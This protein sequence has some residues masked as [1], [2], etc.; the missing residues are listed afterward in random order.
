MSRFLVMVLSL[1][2]ALPAGAAPLRVVAINTDFFFY[3]KDGKPAGI[4]Y[5]IL[6]YF[7]K[8]R[9]MT[10]EVQWADS[11]GDLLDLVKSGK[12]DVAAG[13]ITITPERARQV[14]FTTGY[15]PVQ[16]MLVERMNDGAKSLEELAGSKVGAFAKTTAEDALKTVPG[17]QIVTDGN[18]EDML[19]A[20]DKGELRAAAADSSAIIPVLEQHPN[21]KIGLA[22]GA[23]QS[24]GFA[25]PKDSA[26]KE[27]LSQNI[28]RLKESGIYFRIVTAHMGSR[29]SEIVRA[30]KIE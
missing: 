2:F 26:L 29:A 20:I 12:A 9:N 22:L 3:E 27:P 11:F 18:L 10:V 21:L 17:I 30:A 28:L 5:E 24:F 13:T 19:K 16:V 25:L 8:S 6:E 23:Q 4:E 14:A 15:F 7:A 1:A